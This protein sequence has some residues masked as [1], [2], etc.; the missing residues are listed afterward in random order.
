MKILYIPDTHF[1]YADHIAL[2]KVY[3]L[4]KKEKPDC[5]IQAGD[6][7]DLYS[8]S[9]YDKHSSFTTPMNELEFGMAQ[10]REF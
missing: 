2:A 9:R 7:L 6:L 8:F 3:N 5:I 1:P 4:I 10:A